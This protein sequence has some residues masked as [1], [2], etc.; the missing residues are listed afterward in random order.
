MGSDTCVPKLNHSA[1]AVDWRAFGM[2][3][4]DMIRA[5]GK[6]LYVKVDLRLFFPAGYLR[7]EEVRVDT[8]TLPD[9]T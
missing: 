4:V 3:A 2:N 9:R 6:R 8:L 5:A 1:S 7:P